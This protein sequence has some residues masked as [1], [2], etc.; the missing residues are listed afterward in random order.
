[1]PKSFDTDKTPWLFTP[2]GEGE[3]NDYFSADHSKAIAETSKEVLA[4]LSESRDRLSG[5][6]WYDFCYNQRRYK[7]TLMKFADTIVRAD[8]TIKNIK[9]RL[10][11]S[12]MENIELKQRIKE[13]EGKK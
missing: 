7:L 1:M 3:M 13:L 2:H 6:V 11:K 10:M 5:E 4:S 12:E 9:S 8:V